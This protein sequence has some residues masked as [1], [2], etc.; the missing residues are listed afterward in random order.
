MF[1]DRPE[2]FAGGGEIVGVAGGRVEPDHGVAGEE[3]V[4]EIVD[5]VEGG[6]GVVDPVGGGFRA[7][8]LADREEGDAGDETGEQQET[9]VDVLEQVVF[10]GTRGRLRCRGD[11]AGGRHRGRAGLFSRRW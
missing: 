6:V 11:C 3:R 2:G 9:A 10:H 5:F 4:A 8:D 7:V 1:L